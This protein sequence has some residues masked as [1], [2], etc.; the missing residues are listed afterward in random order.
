[1]RRGTTAGL[2]AA[3]IA[4]S[5][6]AGAGPAAVQGTTVGG[7]GAQYYLNDAFTGKAN[8][9]LVY[10]DHGDEVYVG[11]WDGNGSDTLMV[12]RG[13]TFYARNSATSGPADVVFAYGDPGD[14]VLV[15][16][17][18]GNGTDTLAVRRGNTFHVKTV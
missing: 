15:G 12:R 9:E 4:A 18:D 5:M 6:M 3:V 2:A 13:I 10:G 7:A 11:D 8:I 17:W 16:D 1:M 14:T